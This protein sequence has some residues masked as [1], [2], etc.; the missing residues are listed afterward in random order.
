[1]GKRKE[2]AGKPKDGA[3][4]RRTKAEGGGEDPGVL[5]CPQCRGERAFV[6]DAYLAVCRCPECGTTTEDFYVRTRNRLWGDP[7]GRKEAV[8]RA[9]RASG[10]R[11]PR[12]ERERERRTP[13]PP[14]DDSGPDEAKLAALGFVRIEC[15]CGRTF[16]AGEGAAFCPKCLRRHEVRGGSAKA[17]EDAAL[18]CPRCGSLAAHRPEKGRAY[19]CVQCGAWC[20][21]PGDKEGEREA[22]RAAQSAAGW[23]RARP[24]RGRL[25]QDALERVRALVAEECCNWA[26][27]GPW[28]AKNWCW[29]KDKPCVFFAAPERKEPHRCAWFEEA[30]VAAEEHADLTAE[31]ERARWELKIVAAAPGGGEPAEEG[32]TAAAPAE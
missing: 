16:W 15:P 20:H 1:V 10:R 25:V 13:A 3:G 28:G 14:P 29:Q 18:R 11:W 26:S 8:E 32:T 17:L 31:Y 22:V 19:L 24:E 9:I 27:E 23:R 2:K 21:A 4:R 7:P 5:Y 30:V 12:P 6:W